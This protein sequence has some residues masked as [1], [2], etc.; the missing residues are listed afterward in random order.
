MFVKAF[1]DFRAMWWDPQN[2]D[3]IIA[4]SDG[5]LNISYDR[6]KTVDHFVNLPVGEFYTVESDMEEPYNIYGG[7]QDHDSWK[8]PS[9]SWSGEVNIADWI[10][11]GEGDGMYNK[12]DPTD[13]RWIINSREFGS[14]RRIDQK[15]RTIT[16]IMPRRPKGQ[17]PL[18]WN[19]TPPIALSPH[20]AA[21]VYTGAQVLLRSLNRGDVVAGNQPGPDDGRCGQDV[22]AGQHPAL[23]A[24]DGLGVAGHRRR[25]LGRAPTM[26]RCR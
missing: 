14:H 12:V 7:M 18:R 5:G 13:S 3:R 15:L 4:G 25:D 26:A 24:D 10:T 19:W 21:I 20:N 6:G 2:P 9:N 22:R 16:D 17:V 11:V 8:A 1:G 23:H